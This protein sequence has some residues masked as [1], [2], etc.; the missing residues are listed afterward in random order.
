MEYNH[1]PPGKDFEPEEEM[2]AFQASEVRCLNLV[3][4]KLVIK[5]AP[6]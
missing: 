5:A 4:G 1:F 6:L 3:R 2:V